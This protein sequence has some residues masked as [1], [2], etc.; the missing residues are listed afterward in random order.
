MAG[1]SMDLY[2]EEDGNALIFSAAVMTVLI[3]F[4]GLAVDFGFYI[5]KYENARSVA[6]AAMQD[7]NS[8]TAYYSSV[9]NPAGEF[10]NAVS[11]Y[12]M[13]E[14]G[15]MTV[16]AAGLRRTYSGIPGDEKAVIDATITIKD[17]YQTMFMRII[18]IDTLPIR[19]TKEVSNTFFI[20]RQWLPGMPEEAWPPEESEPPE[21]SNPAE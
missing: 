3:L 5:N 15:S 13:L 2:K 11:E 8:M 19:V 10:H 1:K 9:P 18:G 20:G 17:T 4:L 16:A 21:E 12:A 6:Q 7:V 14:G